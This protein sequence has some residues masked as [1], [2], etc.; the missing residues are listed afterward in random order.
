MLKGQKRFGNSDHSQ[1]QRSKM[2]IGKKTKHKEFFEWT[3]K[4]ARNL[5]STIESKNWR[6]IN[7]HFVI[8]ENGLRPLMGRDLFEALGIYIKQQQ[9]ANRTVNCI[10]T[11]NPVKHQI[12]EEFPGFNKRIGKP[13]N[14]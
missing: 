4:D 8:V 14:H 12:A 13:K 10:N 1:F 6:T 9:A 2:G 11:L 3:T 7:A 5:N